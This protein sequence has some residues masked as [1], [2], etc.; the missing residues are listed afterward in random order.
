MSV[1]LHV[2]ILGWALIGFNA[3][4]PLIMPE[5]IP[6]EVS[7]IS[8]IDL[9]LKR[10]NFDTALKLL[11][12]VAARSPR[13]ETW[14]ARRGEVLLQANRPD[15]ARKAYSDALTALGTLPPARRNVPAIADLEKRIRLELQ[16]LDGPGP[17]K[18]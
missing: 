13:K 18:P 4:K 3:S 8:A 1:L 11:D 7:I 6:V 10:K 2:G 5:E 12:S 16:H 15:E 14:L 17:V 9:E